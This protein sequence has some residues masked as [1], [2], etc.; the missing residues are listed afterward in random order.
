MLRIVDP[1]S[2]IWLECLTDQPGCQFY[3][4]NFIPE[5]DRSGKQTPNLHFHTFLYIFIILTLFFY[6]KWMKINENVWNE[7]I[8]WS[9]GHQTRNLHYCYYCTWYII[10]HS[11]IGASMN[12]RAFYTF[13]HFCKF[14]SLKMHYLLILFN[15]TQ[16]AKGGKEN[17][18]W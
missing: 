15:L 18:L 3:T 1:G 11:Y 4:G 17:K 14:L 12:I 13:L 16:K 5:N 10:Q 8:V 7:S 6:W 2:G 9:P